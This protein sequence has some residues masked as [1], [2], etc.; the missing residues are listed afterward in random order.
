MPTRVLVPSGVLG[1]GFDPEALQAGLSR[2][3]DIISIDGGSTDSGPY[4]LGTGSSKYSLSSTLAEWSQLVESA[5]S[6]GVPLVLGS[7]GTCGTDRMVD[8][9]VELTGDIANR[10]GKRIRIA[11]IKSSQDIE[12]TCLAFENGRLAA[13]SHAPD[14][15][16]DD[17]CRCSNIVALAGA[18][19]VQAALET[20]ADIVIAGRA[21]DT[22][23]I[24][25]LPLRNGD[26]PGGAW[27]GAKIGECGALCSTNPLS[28]VIEIEF[29]QHGCS[30]EPLAAGAQCTPHS[31]CA[32][33]LYENADP[34][35]M[36]EPGGVL[37]ARDATYIAETP[38]RVRIEGSRW[39]ASDSYTVKLEGAGL[40]GYQAMI[41][42]MLRDRRYVGNAGRW[43]A[44]LREF[45]EGEI[46]RRTGMGRDAY[47]LEFRLIGVDAALGSLETGTALPNEVGVM[48]IVTADSQSSATEIA[49][50]ANP[51]MLHF[52]LS[53]T[54]ELPTFAFPYSPAETERGPVFEFL[55][56]HALALD[57][58][59]DA[60]RLEVLEVGN[61][62]AR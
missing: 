34:H 48:F 36:V 28:G 12:T 41:L 38:A 37:D 25:A 29:D 51:F 21:T 55:L 54:G 1:L 57:D 32:H 33:M 10:L 35:E 11:T 50:L 15:S 49:K 30:V 23:G 44:G 9:M 47:H 3:P 52:P 2:D 14:I 19:Q 8:W 18:E 56:N 17:I 5:T 53:E 46:D 60:F 26:H 61:G 45:L 24:A 39:V 13:L 62:P 22:A 59:M 58:P 4:Y 7:A 6:R 20:D 16:A 27:H 43:V 40:A 42:V 31:V